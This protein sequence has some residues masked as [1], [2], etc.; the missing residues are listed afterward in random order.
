[1]KS[2][3]AMR[4]WSRVWCRGLSSNGLDVEAMGGAMSPWFSGVRIPGRKELAKSEEARLKAF[5]QFREE[6]SSS[7]LPIEFACAAVVER[8]PVIL[9]DL[10]S[11]EI[12]FLE[13]QQR[14]QLKQRKQYPVEEFTLKEADKVL[15]RDQLWAFDVLDFGSKGRLGPLAFDKHF[16]KEFRRLQGASSDEDED[17]ELEVLEQGAGEEEEEEGEEDDGVERSVDDSIKQVADDSDIKMKK[18]DEKTQEILDEIDAFEST[19]QD[20]GPILDDDEMDDVQWSMQMEDEEEDLTSTA[21]FQPQPRISDADHAADFQSLRRRLQRT[22][23][24]IIQ[25]HDPISN[26]LVWRF[27]TAFRQDNQEVLM[28]A[29]QRGV[30]EQLGD[31][32]VFFLGRTPAGYVFDKYSDQVRKERDAFGCHT[33]FYRGERLR[34]DVQVASSAVEDYA[35]ITNDE[36]ARYVPDAANDPYWSVAS[37]FLDD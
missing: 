32:D 4:Q 25:V 12:D 20:L 18:P 33:L 2:R 8:M 36:L 28:D 37:Q 15:R 27:P 26:E 22:L 11:W 23:Y 7:G 34:G 19:T 3:L 10:E 17:E 1:M 31:M 30:E 6:A 21:D 29:A 5:H 13:V 24:L 16:Q 9:P 14:Q 35:W